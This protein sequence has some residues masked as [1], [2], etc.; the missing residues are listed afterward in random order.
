MGNAAI[1]DWLTVTGTLQI[2]LAQ[3]VPAHRAFARFVADDVDADDPCN[4]MLRASFL[5]EESFIEKVLDTLRDQP[6]S[7]EVPKQLRPARS[8]GRIERPVAARDRAIAVAYSTGGYTLT[9]IGCYYKIHLSTAGRFETRP[10][11][12][13]NKK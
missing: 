1:P 6:I 9:K 4:Q 2:F 3:R 5:G 11:N 10:T 12:A 7:A 13:R 8:L